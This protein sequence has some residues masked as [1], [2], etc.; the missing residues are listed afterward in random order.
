MGRLLLRESC[1]SVLAVALLAFAVAGLASLTSAGHLISD[2]LIR[3]ATSWPPPVA[4]D[5]PDVTVV[6]LDARSIQQYRDWPW[7]RTRWVELIERLDAA[8]AR[9]IALDIDF[10]T[11]RDAEADAALGAAIA[12]SGHVVLGAFRQFE[13]VEGLGEV[14]TAEFPISEIAAGAARVGGA[15]IPLDSDGTVRRGYRSL[16]LIGRA[17]PSLPAATLDVAR[18]G[19]PRESAAATGR[20][21]FALDFRRSRPAVPVLSAADVLAGR[22]DPGQV[23]G[24]AVLVGATAQILQDVW[25]TPISSALPGVLIQAI[26]YRHLAAEISGQSVLEHAGPLAGAALILVVSIA[27]RLLCS[28]ST[29]E[30]VLATIALTG[31]ALTLIP[32]VVVTSGYLVDPNGPLLAIAGHYV[33]GVE[34]IRSQIARRLCE[35]ERSISTMAHVGRITAQFGPKGVKPALHLLGKQTGA[36]S[37]MLLCLNAEGDFDEAPLDWSPAGAVPPPDLVRA[38]NA[39]I[40]RSM[41]VVPGGRTQRLYLPL[42]AGRQAVGVLIGEYD[43]G[44]PVERLGISSVEAVATLVALAIFNDRLVGSLREVAD[45]ALAANRAKSEFLANMSHELRTPM[46]AVLGYLDV[47]ADPGGESREELM[48]AIRSNGNHLL[49]I[50][51]DILDHAQIE[52]GRMNVA[53]VAVSPALLCREVETLLRSQAEEKG[54]RFEV[55]L[56]PKLPGRV[57]TDPVRLRQILINLLRNAIKFTESGF[58]RLHAYRSDGGDMLHFDV[59]DSGIGMDAATRSTIFERFAQ[60]DASSTRRYGGIGLG[61]SIV[62]RLAQLLGGEVRV[63][64][65]PGEGSVFRLLLPAREVE[66]APEEGPPGS[67]PAFATL[68]GRVLLAEDSSDNQRIFT[69]FLRRSGL[70]V[71]LADNGK[72]A[73]GLGA[74]AL[75]AGTPY[76]LILMDI[77]MPVMNGYEATRALREAGHAGPII[78]LTAHALKGERD[79]CLRAGCDDYLS[80]PVDREH[81]LER[82]RA[83]LCKGD[84]S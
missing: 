37:L 35:S 51:N 3:I 66:D 27:A 53:R 71:D 24:R 63:E 67:P 11:P 65:V 1:I 60:A 8:G 38:R 54:L 68:S 30:R 21:T 76:D 56:D 49:N 4:D 28:G 18:A 83:W 26:Q 81:L 74:A 5:L 80:K 72:I 20:G 61:L 73:C 52:S 59:A 15:N 36:D 16:E 31:L 58:V 45:Q 47:L 48:E 40:S 79:R 2:V 84:E 43:A 82:A 41:I 22:I 29:R 13:H 75:D 19:T 42:V 9:A 69:L 34:R 12:A 25:P 14:E 23:A 6:A 70:A 44:T 10:S 39:V 64:S 62:S 46:M 7:P 32:V 77:D 50:L 55:E 17:L 33:L 78:A 57:E